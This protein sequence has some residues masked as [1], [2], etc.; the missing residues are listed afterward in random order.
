MFG[1]H[2]LE[3]RYLR[4]SLLVLRPIK[5]ARK[6]QVLEKATQVQVGDGDLSTNELISISNQRV[7][8]NLNLCS[9]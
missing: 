5:I 8:A 2:F 9:Q 6:G 1:C 4:F 3:A 7:P